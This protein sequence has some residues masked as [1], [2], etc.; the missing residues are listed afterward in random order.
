M[1]E[2]PASRETV[3]AREADALR[4]SPNQVEGAAEDLGESSA[5]WVTGH[6][7]SDFVAT[8]CH[9]CARLA[10]QT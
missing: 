2:P 1:K 3:R 5:D 8:E 7:G 9:C 4:D 10:E 6:L